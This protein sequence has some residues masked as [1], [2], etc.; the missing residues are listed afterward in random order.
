VVIALTLPSQTS[1]IHFNVKSLLANK[2]ELQQ[3]QAMVQF[4]TKDHSDANVLILVDGHSMADDGSIVFGKENHH[5][6]LS[7]VH[8]LFWFPLPI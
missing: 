7:L 4:L 3:A 1:I 5:L 6:P 2:R 8:L